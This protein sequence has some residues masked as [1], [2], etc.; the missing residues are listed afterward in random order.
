M[1]GSH[2][3]WKVELSFRAFELKGSLVVS[4]GSFLRRVKGPQP[5]SSCLVRITYLRRPF[6]PR[7]SSYSSIVLSA[8]PCFVGINTSMI[9]HGMLELMQVIIWGLSQNCRRR[10]VRVNKLRRR[11]FQ[12]RKWLLSMSVIHLSKSNDRSPPF[13]CK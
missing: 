10:H 9:S 13:R 2:A 8:T 4:K 7:P 1:M 6:S 5:N 3:T 11:R 12:G